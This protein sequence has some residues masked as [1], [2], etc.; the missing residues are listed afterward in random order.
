MRAAVLSIAWRN[1]LRNRRRSLITAAAI[2][3]GLTALI[4]LWGFNDGAHNTMMRNYQELFVGA[5]QIHR[6]GYFQHPE[7]ANHIREPEA[8]AAA[9][10]A[11]GVSSWTPRLMGFALAAGAETSAGVMLAGIDP[12]R[13]PRVTRIAEH[14]AEGRFIQPGDGLVCVLGAAG[15]Q[16]LKVGIGD[17]VILLSQDRFGA[18]AA[19]RLRLVGII[20]GGDPALER[21][22]LLAP[23]GTVQRMLAMEGRVTD[24]VA[25]VPDD[26]LDA[27]AA[28]LGR[29][30]GGR[31]LEV[32]RWFDMF[33]IMKEWVALDNGFY[34][35]FLG[36]VLVIVVA[37]VINTVMVSMIE[38][39]REFGV[40]MALGT[41]RADIAAIVGAEAAIIGLVG[42]AS[43]SAMGLALVAIFGE[44]GIDLSEMSESLSR[45]YMDPV[46]RTE[47][48][49][50]HLV[51]TVLAMLAAA[52][53]SAVYP[54]IKAVRLEPAE[55]IRHVG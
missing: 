46:V 50:D 24:V 52:V 53:A 35:I 54:A 37:G 55:A 28:A 21:S 19:E 49:T 17:E 32:L 14:I 42:T 15:A 2:A 40:L 44:I 8:V 7:L 23:L 39:T 47:I 16:K 29:G 12:E 11:A 26:R 45:F 30:L 1:V 10:E 13:E 27:V 3:I 51:I 36:I 22:I 20:R 33:P 31:G 6:Q 4:F 38:R 41:R 43:G 25:R 48:D 34:Y 9:L 18:L 5:L